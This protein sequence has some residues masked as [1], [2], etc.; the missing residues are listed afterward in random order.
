MITTRNAILAL[1]A[2]LVVGLVTA[3]DDGGGLPVGQGG[4]DTQAEIQELRDLH[5]RMGEILDGLEASGAAAGGDVEE[6]RTRVERLE[7]QV[8][9]SAGRE[10][11][12]QLEGIRTEA[13]SDGDAE[14]LLQRLDRTRGDLARAFGA[15]DEGGALDEAAFGRDLTTSFDALAD[16]LESGEDPSEA[17]DE[18]SM[19]LEQLAQEG[20]AADAEAQEDG[21]GAQ[22][23]DTAGEAEED[24]VDPQ[25]LGAQIYAQNCAACHQGQG[26]G[27]EG[28]YPAIAG[29]PFVTGDPEPVLA[30]VIHGR[31]GMPSFASLS[32]RE[33][34]AVV[35]HER[36]SWGNDADPVDAELAA[37]VREGGDFGGTPT[38]DPDE[39]GPNYR[40]GAAN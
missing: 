4:G 24:A 17:F 25:I 3:Q 21:A 39:G 28:V 23:D 12:S 35:T 5:E 32:D 22:T 27:V 38:A 18:V 2:T 36:T 6:L 13:E 7:R 26:E 37:T 30:T 20:R 33:I 10:A 11:L 9:R 40:P 29:N 8:R 19:R 15:D 16:M 31:G 1:A 14:E 34:A